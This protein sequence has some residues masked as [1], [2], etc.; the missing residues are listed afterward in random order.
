MGRDMTSVAHSSDDGSLLAAYRAGQASAFEALVRRHYPGMLRIA[1]RR[2]GLGATADD[3]VQQALIRAHRYL[4]GTTQ[5]DNVAAWL[6]RVVH[7]CATDLLNSERRQRVGY[8]LSIDLPAPADSPL[9]RQELKAIVAEAIGQLPDVYRRPLTMRYL[10]GIEAREIAA[11]L[12]ENIH[13]VKSRLARGRRELR[14]RL[15]PVLRRAGYV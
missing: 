14:R 12:N 9:E 2:C 10:Y 11:R 1:E 13:S 7:N 5:I 8:E 4:R 6:R 15:E 3:A